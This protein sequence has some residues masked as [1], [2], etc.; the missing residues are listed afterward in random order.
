MVVGP[1]YNAI[2]GVALGIDKRAR[3]PV[4]RGLLAVLAESSASCR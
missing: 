3:R 4:L 2:M 1:E